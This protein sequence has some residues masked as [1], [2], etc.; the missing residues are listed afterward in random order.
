MWSL[1]EEEGYRESI[2]KYAKRHPDEVICILANLDKY[3]E[4]LCSI[5]DSRRITGKYIHNEKKGIL[6]L[7][8]KSRARRV[9]NMKETPYIFILIKLQGSYISCL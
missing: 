6:A 4:A 9:K 5:D 8:Q 7:D 2:K 1:R 3:F